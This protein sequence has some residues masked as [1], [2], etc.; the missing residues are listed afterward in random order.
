[1]SSSLPDGFAIRPARDDE[2]PAVAELMNAYD[3]AMAGGEA[4]SA[5]DV[6]DGWRKLGGDGGA[7]LVETPGGSHAGYFELFGRL[8]EL[9]LDGYVHPGFTGR[10]IGTAIVRRGEARARELGAPRLLSGTLAQDKP[11]RLL[12]EAEG[13]S[14]ERVFY[15]M[16]AELDGPQPEPAPPPGGLVLRTFEPSDAEAFHAA[17]EEAF[18]DHWDFHPEPFADFRARTIDAAGFDPTLWWLVL[19]GDEVAATIRCTWKRFGMGWINMLAARRP[20]RRRGLGEL[21]LRTAFAEFARR[22]ETRV[23]LGVDAESETGATR[24]YERAGMHVVFQANI[25]QKELA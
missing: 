23:G 19:D 21:L 20:W 2:A 10:G 1:M 4:V 22:G 24:L 17:T 3:D 25:F 7:W 6:R 11:A 13:W 15:R 8:H 14:L 9:H 18:A 5:D 12:F 16:R